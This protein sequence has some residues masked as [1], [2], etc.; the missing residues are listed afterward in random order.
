MHIL[1]LILADSGIF[2]TLAYLCTYCFTHIQAYLQSYTCRGIFGHIWAYFSGFR[3]IQNHDITGSN[4][5]NQHLLFKSG[6]SFKSLFKS[7]FLIFVSK[8][9]IQHFFLQDSITIIITMI[10]ACR[11]RQHVTHT[12]MLPKLVPHP[13]HSRQHATHTS[14]LPTE[15][16]HSR[17]SRQHTT[18]GRSSPT[19]AS[20]HV[21][22]VSKNS[23]P[24]LKL[25]IRKNKAEKLQKLFM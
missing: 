11:S 8:V 18:H 3:Y 22:H 17:H 7:N 12:S 9:N 23:T 25:K 14:M 4:N 6:S 24:F 19:Q 16:H 5:V 13:H 21:T 2:R 10:I 1:N 20:H 15:A